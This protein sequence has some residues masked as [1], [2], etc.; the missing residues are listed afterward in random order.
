[1]S[2]PL[3]ESVA[4]SS[5]G[6]FTE[7]DQ[8]AYLN[9]YYDSIDADDGPGL[10]LGYSLEWISKTLQGKQYYRETRVWVTIGYVF[11]INDGQL[12]QKSSEIEREFPATMT[13]HLTCSAVKKFAASLGLRVRKDPHD[14]VGANVSI[15]EDLR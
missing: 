1:M 4:R 2:I 5:N 15:S 7:F 14:P 8:S 11:W 6:A 3:S 13:Y 12:N 9:A 10:C